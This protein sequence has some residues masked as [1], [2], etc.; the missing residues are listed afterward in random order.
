MQD[1]FWKDSSQR[2]VMIIPLLFAHRHAVGGT[3]DSDDL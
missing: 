1:S 2:N 3:D